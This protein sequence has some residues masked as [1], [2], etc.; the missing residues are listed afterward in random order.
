MILLMSHTTNLM[1]PDV[2]A[3]PEY[4]SDSATVYWTLLNHS[5]PD[6]LIDKLVPV[7]PVSEGV[8]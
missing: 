5:C 6:R 4:P 1:E 7:A 3:M 8:R 2:D